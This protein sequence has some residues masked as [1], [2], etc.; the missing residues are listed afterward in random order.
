MWSC[1]RIWRNIPFSRKRWESDSTAFNA[2]DI[3]EANTTVNHH[4]YDAKNYQE[5]DFTYFIGS[6]AEV[7]IEDEIVLAASDYG[8][9]QWGKAEKYMAN[10][11]R[12]IAPSE[13]IED[14]VNV[15]RLFWFDPR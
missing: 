15:L 7:A 13:V 6:I 11:A 8:D 5:P 3:V 9:P 2:A 4:V 10:V 12:Q 1:H 14:L